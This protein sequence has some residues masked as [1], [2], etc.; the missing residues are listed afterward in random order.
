MKRCPQCKATYLDDTLNFCL[1]D[2]E[3]LVE[4]AEPATAILTEPATQAFHHT[5]A[6]EAEPRTVVGDST[7]RQS[8]SAHRAAQPQESG[9][10]PAAQPHRNFDK[11]LLLAADRPR[12][13]RSRGVCG[14]SIS[15]I[16][17][18]WTDQ[19]DRSPSI[20]ESQRRSGH[21]LSLRR[22]SGITHFS[23]DSAARIEGQPDELSDSIQRKRY[24]TS[25]RSRA[26]SVSMR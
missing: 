26:I 3:W 13:Y 8:L 10:H 12:G 25:R 18:R 5:T 15:W 21:R 6:S 2:G 24:W 14:L 4:D 16:G 22:S 17:R 19:F 7:E 1:E 11:R 20:C 23:T 9:S